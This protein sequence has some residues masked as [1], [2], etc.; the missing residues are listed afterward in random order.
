[1]A[2]F[3]GA[4]GLDTVR[5]V[6][7]LFFGTPHERYAARLRRGWGPDDPSA[8]LWLSSAARALHEG[9]RIEVPWWD[10]LWFS[11]H[12]P[13]A[14]AFVLPARRGQ[15]LV[16][17]AVVVAPRDAAL[18]LDL[19][20]RDGEALR[21]VGS[22]ARDERRL[23][24]E[25]RADGEYVLRAQSELGRDVLISLVQRAEPS[26]RLPVEGVTAAHIR[27]SFGDPRDGGRREHEG[28]DIFARRG[29]NVLAAA[30]GLVSSVGTNRLGGK[31]V[32]IARPSRG[33]AHYY[34]H[35]ETQLVGAG[36]RVNAGDVIG[37]VGNTGNA[38]GTAPHLHFGIYGALGAVDPLPYVALPRAAPP[39]AARA[40]AR[41]GSR[42]DRRPATGG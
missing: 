24:L 29:T 8:P 32:W 38:R 30:D 12:R 15:R 33:E 7:A 31:V 18:F 1:M 36:T 21:H 4:G 23:A 26:L 14:R 17:D 27:S 16:A 9:R 5:D 35:L 10:E 19:F 37:T 13:E 34:A 11:A 42:S 20:L 6:A 41:A 39:S 25:I 22:A 3:V 2:A 40:A 28:I